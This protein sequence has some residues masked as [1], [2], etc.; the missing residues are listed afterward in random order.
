VNPRDAVFSDDGICTPSAARE[1]NFRL[2]D[3]FKRM[4][5]TG[6]RRVKS[7]S[8]SPGGFCVPSG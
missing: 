8:K 4:S 3:G 1:Y 6:T 5:T 7:L 2:T